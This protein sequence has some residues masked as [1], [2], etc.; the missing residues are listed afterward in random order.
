MAIP[1]CWRVSWDALGNEPAGFL[2]FTQRARAR[3]FLMIRRAS[4]FVATI[5]PRG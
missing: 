4:G 2:D 3:G 1:Q 5:E